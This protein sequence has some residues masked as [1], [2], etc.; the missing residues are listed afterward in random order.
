MHSAT[1]TALLL[2]GFQND[3][4]APDGAMNAVIEENARENDVLENTGRIL[5]ALSASDAPIINLPIH[6]SPTYEELVR[7]TGLG[8]LHQIKA[9]D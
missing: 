3:Y 9:D 6:F 2:I 5:S 7:P 8:I 4:F 1:R